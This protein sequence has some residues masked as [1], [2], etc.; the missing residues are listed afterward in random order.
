MRIW[1]I[2]EVMLTEVLKNG[3]SYTFT[4]YQVLIKAGMKLELF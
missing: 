4:D 2:T 1:M 3:S